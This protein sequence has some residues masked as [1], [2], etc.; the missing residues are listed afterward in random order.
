LLRPDEALVLGALPP[1]CRKV[2]GRVEAEGPTSMRVIRQ[3]FALDSRA[4]QRVLAEL[5]QALLV[6]NY[7]TVKDGPGW[8][9]CV[10]EL[11]SRA[12]PAH[13]P[14]PADERRRDAALLFL[15]TMVTADARQLAR[16]FR[17]SRKD[18]TG[19]LADL[20]DED[21]ARPCPDGVHRAC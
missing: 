14:R 13:D 6:T 20:A 10:I 19:I 18:A 4:S 11:T 8:P 1:A 5:G 2:F 12:F 21:R 15:D 3:D 7:G 17:W 16:A 9:S